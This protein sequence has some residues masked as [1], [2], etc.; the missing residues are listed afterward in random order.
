MKPK[1][2]DLRNKPFQSI[3]VLHQKRKTTTT[4]TRC[5]PNSIKLFQMSC[6]NCNINCQQKFLTFNLL[7]HFKQTNEQTKH[8]LKPQTIK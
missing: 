7:H 6:S 5:R 2:K 8:E 1:T 4:S 3:C